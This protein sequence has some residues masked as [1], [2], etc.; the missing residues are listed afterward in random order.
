M[1]PVIG[2]YFTTARRPIGRTRRRLEPFAVAISASAATAAIVGR[3]IRLDGEPYTVIGVAPAAYALTD[4]TRAGI[5]GGFSSQLWTP[6]MFSPAQ[7]DNFGSHYLGVLAKLKPGVSLAQAQDDL[8]RVTRGIA[9]RHPEDMEGRGVLVQSLQ[10]QLAGNVR[11]QLLVLSAGGRLRPVDWVREHR[12]PS[13]NPCHHPAPGNR[14]QKLPRRRAIANRPTAPDR[15]RRARA[16]RWTRLAGRRRGWRSTSSSRTGRSTLPR[17]REAGLQV[18]VLLVR[19]RRHWPRGDPVRTGAR[20]ARRT[21]RPPELAARRR[22]D[23]GRSRRPRPAAN[24]NG[25][26]RDGLHG[27]SV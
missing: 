7:R 24:G 1:P 3:Q 13:R 17:L 9:E 27:R 23:G 10:E 25:R 21:H 8:E 4:P 11:A 18:E 2:R 14:D 26:R 16:R 6:L 22:T 20:D 15:K 19:A 12:Q 5:T